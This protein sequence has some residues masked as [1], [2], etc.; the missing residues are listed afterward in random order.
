MFLQSPMTKP[1]ATDNLGLGKIGQIAMPVQDFRRAVAFYRDTLRIK[2]LFEAPPALAFF[3][4]DGVRLMLDK[5]EDKEFE[6]HGS[7]LYFRVP[8]ID[9]AYETLRARGVA[10]EGAPH[11]IHKTPDYELWMC[12]FR[13]TER[14]M[15]ALMA[16]VSIPRG[17]KA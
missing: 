7:V 10:F 14:N 17:A 1:Q 3:D 6:R 8:D 4:C 2:F 13:D 5:P 12:F 9:S 16:E 15:L 11:V